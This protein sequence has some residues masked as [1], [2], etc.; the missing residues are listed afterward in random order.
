M[1]PL[2]S[3]TCYG[4]AGMLSF[5]SLSKTDVVLSSTEAEDLEAVARTI[6]EATSWM[7]W[8]TFAAKFMML[9]GSED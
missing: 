1:L 6:V 4:D 2:S 8:W 7:Y 9:S 3:L 5:D